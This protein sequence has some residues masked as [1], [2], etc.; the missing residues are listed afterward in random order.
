MD[1]RPKKVGEEVKLAS[2]KTTTLCSVC[3]Y[4][5]YQKNRKRKS[6]KKNES[7][8]KF[9]D[10]LNDYNTKQKSEGEENGIN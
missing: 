7:L 2:S 6:R 1:D 3:F 5:K 4:E 9:L 10:K 8:T